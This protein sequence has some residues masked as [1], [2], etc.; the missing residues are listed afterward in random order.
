MHLKLQNFNMCNASTLY[1]QSANQI[2]DVYIASSA[3]KIWP[4]PKNVEISHVTMTTPNWGIVRHHKANT[5]RGQQN[6]EVCGFS[7]SKDISGRAK[8]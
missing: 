7:R 8:F 6:L 1:I 5:S 4:E 3:P 2:W